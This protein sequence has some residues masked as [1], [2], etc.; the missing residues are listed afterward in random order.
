MIS[1]EVVW[2]LRLWVKDH[3]EHYCYADGMLAGSNP[4]SEALTHT[5]F[6]GDISFD[7]AGF[8]AL[9]MRSELK[10]WR[11]TWLG[12][13]RRF[14]RGDETQGRWLIDSVLPLGHQHPY[15]CI[16]RLGPY[17]DSTASRMRTRPR[18]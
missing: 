4:H 2:Q 7:T 8:V 3:P 18:N 16:P 10:A 13:N 5:A 17:S 6:G 11:E 15:A 1:P 12:P 14:A 9:N